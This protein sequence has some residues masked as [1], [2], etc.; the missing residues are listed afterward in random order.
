M[1]YVLN[2]CQ[3]SK[4]G[5]PSLGPWKAEWGLSQDRAGICHEVWA[6]HLDS[7]REPFEKLGWGASGPSSQHKIQNCS[8]RCWD[9]RPS[10]GD[11]GL[12]RLGSLCCLTGRAW[13]WAALTMIGSGSSQEEGLSRSEPC[14]RVCAPRENKKKITLFL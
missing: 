13:M 6:V 2:V 9:H 3:F 5:K 11:Y 7:G 14:V 4:M 12:A 10:G 1:V 8:R